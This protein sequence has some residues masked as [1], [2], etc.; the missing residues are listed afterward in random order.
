MCALKLA[1][2]TST[3]TGPAAEAVRRARAQT[4][5]ALLGVI[6]FGS[7]ARAEATDRSDVDLLLVLAPELPIV[8]ELYRPWDEVPSSWG[9]RPVEPH[10]VHLPA[11]GGRVSGLWAEAAL[12]GIVLYERGFAISRRLVEV[13]RR[14]VAGELTRRE[15]HGHSYWVEAA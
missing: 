1:T 15:V 7:W 14:I 10:F 9:G 12:D 5:E 4:G 13:R 6:V 11:A 8:R 2:V 3:L